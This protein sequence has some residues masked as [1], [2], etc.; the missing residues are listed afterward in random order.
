ME[1]KLVVLESAVRWLVS[2][3]LLDFVKRMVEAINNEDITGEE[4]KAW[5]MTEVKSMFSNTASLFITL[6][7]EVALILLRSEIEDGKDGN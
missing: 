3:Q 2:G 1:V 6:A 4:K 7:I 5:V